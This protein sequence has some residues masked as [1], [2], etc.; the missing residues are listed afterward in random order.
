M[1]DQPV[2]LSI[3]LTESSTMKTLAVA[4]CLVLL[5][6]M[7]SAT[8][9]PPSYPYGRG[10]GR[11]GGYGGNDVDNNQNFRQYATINQ[12]QFNRQNVDQDIYRFGGYPYYGGKGYVG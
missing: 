4:L 12:Q 11:Y 2:N 10:Y 5:V 3:L 9:Q 8:F 7:V 1:I 6:A